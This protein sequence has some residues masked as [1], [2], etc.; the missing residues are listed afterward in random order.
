MTTM[1]TYYKLCSAQQSSYQQ[2]INSQLENVVAFI[3]SNLYKTSCDFTAYL[4]YV[5][6]PHIPWLSLFVVPVRA[7]ISQISISQ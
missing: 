1:T 7:E 4:L 6:M 5:C 2:L 3:F